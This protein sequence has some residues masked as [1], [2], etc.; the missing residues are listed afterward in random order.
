MVKQKKLIAFLLSM[1]VVFGLAGCGLIEKT[2]EGK[3]NTVVA[4]IGNKK[5]TKGEFDERFKGQMLMYQKMYKNEN[6]F[7]D[8][9]NQEAVKQIKSNFLNAIVDEVLLMQ[10]AEE[11]KLVPT[12]AELDTEIEKRM[13]ED[14]KGKTEDEFKKE[15]ESYGVTVEQ[16]KENVKKSIIIDK[17]YNEVIKDAK[18]ADEEIQKYYNENLYDYTEKPNTMNI[19]RILVMSEDEA[20]KVIDEYNKGAKFEDLAK[21][22]SKEEDTKNKGGLLGDVA[23][24]DT[25]YDKTFLAMAMH[26]Q[27]GKISP[28]IPTQTGIYIVKMNSKNEYPAK[29]LDTVKEDIRRELLVQAKESKY[30]ETLKTWKEKAK[31]KVYEDRI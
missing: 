1:M 17:V 14:K 21:K 27:V 2:E 29:P 4:S 20:Q 6:F 12:Q 31:I 26:T 10:K 24:N 5:I 7:T 9:N 3:K 30:N 28:A 13:E 23:Y 15:L 16:Y 8:K 22:Y 11:L 18:V 19:S 25:N